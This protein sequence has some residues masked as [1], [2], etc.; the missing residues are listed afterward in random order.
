MHCNY[1]RTKYFYIVVVVAQMASFGDRITAVRGLWNTLFM[2]QKYALD[3]A[4]FYTGNSII[5]IKCQAR[6]SVAAAK[7]RWTSSVRTFAK[8]ALFAGIV[9]GLG[10]T[11]P[12]H[13]PSEI[14]TT[15]PCIHRS[16]FGLTGYQ[17][18]M[19]WLIPVLLRRLDSGQE[20]GIT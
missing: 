11:G 20:S 12:T 15:L 9:G 16:S 10:W 13:G 6:L 3:Y 17:C 8:M 7:L 4:L 19:L 18:F 2:N 1:Q 14:S 5:S